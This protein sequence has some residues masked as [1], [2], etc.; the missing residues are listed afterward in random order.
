M[1]QNP[2]PQPNPH[3]DVTMTPAD[4]RTWAVIGHI[5][6]LVAA[7]LSAGWLS[8]LGPAIVWGVYKERSSF[9]RQSAAGA[10]NFNLV[11]WVLTL[12]G[13]L[14]LFTIVGIPLAFIVWAVALVASVYYH[15]MAAV[16]ANRGELY[17]YPWGITVLR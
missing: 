14:L 7:V 4:E 13:W 17:R 16:A 5:S 6:T 1:T 15:V 3:H 10:F 8:I 12:I 11:I 2:M 9:V